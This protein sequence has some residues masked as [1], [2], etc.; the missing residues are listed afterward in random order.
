VGGT[1][2]DNYGDILVFLNPVF[3]EKGETVIGEDQGSCIRTRVATEKAGGAWECSITI[4]LEK[5]QISVKGPFYDKRNSTM[6]IIGGT[7]LYATARGEMDLLH[8]VPDDKRFA[9]VVHVK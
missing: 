1:K 2:A 5:G 9:F 8:I 7:G 3:D 6:A 4:M